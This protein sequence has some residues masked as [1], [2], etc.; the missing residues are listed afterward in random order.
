MLRDVDARY[1]R[2]LTEHVL[3][4]PL[5]A[6]EYQT[7]PSMYTSSENEAFIGDVKS[8]DATVYTA[9]ALTKDATVGGYW[10][11]SVFSEVKMERGVSL[12]PFKD[13]QVSFS[14]ASVMGGIATEGGGRFFW[15][16][17]LPYKRQI[18]QG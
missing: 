9:K 13:G 16:D 10:L 17:T 2:W 15:P 12:Y 3:G 14:Q 6:V 11:G 7:P 1:I 18:L 8:G 5:P 4:L